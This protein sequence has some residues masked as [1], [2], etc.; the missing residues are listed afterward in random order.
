[1]EVAVTDEKSVLVIGLEPT[2]IDFSQPR[3]RGHWHGRNEGT[4]RT[5]VL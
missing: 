1:M 3:L 5:Q 2:L 4:S